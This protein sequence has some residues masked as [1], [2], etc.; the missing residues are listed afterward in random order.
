MSTSYQRR[1]AL[2][3]VG[4][5]TS[6]RRRAATQI[7]RAWRQ[8][9]FRVIKRRSSRGFQRRVTA[10]VRKT[11]P[12]Q[13]HVMSVMNQTPVTQAPSVYHFT[14]LYYDNT[15]HAPANPKWHRSSNRIYVQNLHFDIRVQA[16]R[17]PADAYSSVCIALVR[18]KRSEPIVD[19]M[20]QANQPNIGPNQP[21]CVIPQLKMVD[22][23]FLPINEQAGNQPP[24][25]MD[26]NYG[27]SNRKASVESLASY[28]NPKVVDLIWHKTV[29]VQPLYQ[30][31]AD[32]QVTFPTGWTAVKEFDYN[33]KLNETWVYPS[34]PA[35]TV[36]FDVFPTVHNKC[37]SLIAWSDS[38]SSS[39][40][41]P[42]MDVQ[43]RMSFKDVD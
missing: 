43:C 19:N 41:H 1:A 18:H 2:R 28:F 7:Q 26:L 27:Y 36:G 14:N 11:E 34:A 4:Q 38:I 16:D 31:A 10:A 23:P 42:M 12:Q 37:Y 24:P 15:A 39:A 21:A 6:S 25:Q 35:D 17:P 13:Y 40:S 5:Y 20:L 30:Q 33:K 9:N 22:A 29:K 32:P 8:R 3:L